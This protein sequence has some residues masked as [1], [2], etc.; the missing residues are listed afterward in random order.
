MI[1]VGTARSGALGRTLAEIAGALEACDGRDPRDLWVVGS[2]PASAWGT[3]ASWSGP[4]RALV[5]PGGF[6]GERVA[7]RAD[8]RFAFAEDL[9]AGADE[10][11]RV[12]PVPRSQAVPPDTDGA[13]AGRPDGIA[14]VSASGSA[15]VAEAAAAWS[16]GRA[17]VLERGDAGV[18]MPGRGAMITATTTLEADEAVSFL[19]TYPAVARALALAGRRFRAT[20][21]TAADLARTMTSY[22]RPRVSL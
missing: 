6:Y 8:L 17:V 18:R 22:A 19:T 9:P 20:M 10:S 5:V 13:D 4:V 7:L 11:V 2:P 12:V 14:R 1:L 16:R 21:P 3:V 15:A